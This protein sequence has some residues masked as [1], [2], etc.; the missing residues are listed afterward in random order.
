MRFPDEATETERRGRKEW[1]TE[2]VESNAVAKKEEEEERQQKEKDENEE[3]MEQEEE[4]E[5]GKTKEG[6]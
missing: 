3:V 5:R 6:R 1:E 2:L 4:E